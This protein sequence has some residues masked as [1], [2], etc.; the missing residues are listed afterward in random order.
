MTREEFINELVELCKKHNVIIN[1]C[2]CCD[3]PWIEDIS[4]L[5]D[6]GNSFTPKQYYQ[7]EGWEGYK[8]YWSS[9]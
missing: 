5:K 2:G 1:S 9:D 4:E 6:T 8:S 3:S 7:E